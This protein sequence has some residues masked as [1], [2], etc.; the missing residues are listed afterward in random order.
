MFSSWGNFFSNESLYG[1]KLARLSF[2]ESRDLIPIKVSMNAC[3]VT[4]LNKW[5]GT[6]LAVSKPNH[7]TKHLTY[8]VIMTP[9]ERLN[10]IEALLATSARYITR[11]NEAIARY[12]EVA[13]RLNNSL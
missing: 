2:C 7:L 10:Q 8:E 9:E 6:V 3:C 12:E 4:I 1:F 5:L 11:H 13:A